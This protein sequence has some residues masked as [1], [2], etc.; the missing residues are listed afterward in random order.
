M[1]G[2]FASGTL[3]SEIGAST[4]CP[5]HCTCLGSLTVALAA[6]CTVNMLVLAV[7]V[8][9]RSVHATT[10]GDNRC[11][12]PEPTQVACSLHIAPGTFEGMC[13]CCGGRVVTA[14]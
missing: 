3:R 1:G 2:A 8:M 4:F 5:R 6:L 14:L 9:C 10:N 12:K 7:H 13:A 11:C